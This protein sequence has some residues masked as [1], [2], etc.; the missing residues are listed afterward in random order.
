MADQRSL[1]ML[2]FSFASRTVA[3]KRFAQGL[4]RSVSVLC[5]SFWTHLSKLTN[6]LNTQTKLGLQP[7][8]L[9]FSPEKLGR[10]AI[11]FTEQDL[12]W[13][14]KS[15]FLQSE[16]WNSLGE[17]HQQ[18]FHHK[19]WQFRSF[20]SNSDSPTKKGIRAPLT[21]LAISQKLYFQDCWK[22]QPVL[23]NA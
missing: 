8:M 14:Q 9:R 20:S 16:R 13:Q 15:A 1:Q 10:C 5:L 22:D 19:P 6:V 21:I 4:S 23:Q 17:P 12:D 7:T 2:A 11:A 18:D 3:Y